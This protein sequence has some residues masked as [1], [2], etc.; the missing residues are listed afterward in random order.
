MVTLTYSSDNLVP[1]SNFKI[2]IIWKTFLEN[3]FMTTHF[4]QS[5][6]VHSRRHFSQRDFW[7]HSRSQFSHDRERIYPA[8]HLKPFSQ[9]LFSRDSSLS[10]AYQNIWKLRE[11]LHGGVLELFLLRNEMYRWTRDFTFETSLI[12]LS[13]IEVTQNSRVRPRIAKTG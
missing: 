11:K 9:E 8:S 1:N 3:V 6:S 13:L 5:P 10:S 7:N 2:H 12:S 4:Y